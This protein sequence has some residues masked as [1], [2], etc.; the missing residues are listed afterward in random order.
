MPAVNLSQIVTPDLATLPLI[1]DVQAYELYGSSS[2]NR[3]LRGIIKKGI[4]SGFKLLP[5]QN[6][7]NVIVTSNGQD[8]SAAIEIGKNWL[9]N[10]KQ[11]FDVTLGV[12]A[13]R[14]STVVLTAFYDGRTLTN[15]VHALSSVKAA[16]LMVV[17]T[18]AEPDGCLILGKLVVPSN[19]TSITLPMINTLDRTIGSLER[20]FYN[21]SADKIAPKSDSWISA[22]ALK[23]FRPLLDK[24]R[25]AATDMLGLDAAWFKEAWVNTYRGGSID[26]EGTI[27]AG[28]KEVLLAG[29]ISEEKNVSTDKSLTITGAEKIKE[30]RVT[31]TGIAPA[32]LTID[33]NWTANQTVVVTKTRTDSALLKIESILDFQLSKGENVGKSHTFKG[34]GQFEL[35]VS[36]D[37]T[38]V[39][40]R[41]TGMK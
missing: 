36:A 7:L 10:V 41:I 34:A 32:T 14:A 27:K 40:T 2:F 26:V 5:A 19:A 6:G 12:P 38:F 33:G 16:Q 23:G 25:A 13:G 39:I 24:V 20:D 8:S 21:V 29:D 4:Y 22:T 3:Q 35:S 11:Q 9:I 1:A 31:F 30:H 37:N 17:N 18:G 15:Q 28:G